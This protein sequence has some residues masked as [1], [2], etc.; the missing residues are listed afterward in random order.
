[1]LTREVHINFGGGGEE[2]RG[3]EGEVVYMKR[4]QL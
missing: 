2:R 3:E 1:M 4:H